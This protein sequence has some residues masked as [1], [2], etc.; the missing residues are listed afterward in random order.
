MAIKEDTSGFYEPFLCVLGHYPVGEPMTKDKLPN[1]G[2]YNK[3]V[4]NYII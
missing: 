3:K 1:I 4:I 2:K